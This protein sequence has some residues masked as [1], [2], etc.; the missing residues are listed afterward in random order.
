MPATVYLMRHGETAWSLSGRHTGVTDIALTEIGKAEASAWSEPLRSV[1]F[2]R[3]W[4]S[5]RQRA[6]GTCELAGLGAVAEIEPDLAEWDYGAYEGLTSVAIRRER[7]TWSLFFDG[8]PGGETPVQV[9]CRADRLIARIRGATGT[10]ALF[11]HGHFS[12]V[13]GVRWIGLPVSAARHFLLGPASL[14]VLGTEHGRSEDPAIARWN[15]MP[16]AF[17]SVVCPPPDIERW[18]NEG[19]EIPRLPRP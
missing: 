8:C 1:L 2:A 16:G 19:G 12:R 13:L 7:P 3:V 4:T 11:G 10:F 6:I 14:S 5:P 18:E 15:A 17:G 9:G